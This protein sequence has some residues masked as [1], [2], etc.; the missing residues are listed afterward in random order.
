L[1]EAGLKD[2][3]YNAEAQ[4]I[5]I[6]MKGE[7]KTKDLTFEFKA[8]FPPDY[9]SSAPKVEL[10]SKLEEQETV[11]EGIEKS[12][13]EFFTSWSNFSFLI[14]L[15]NTISRTIFN[16]STLTCILC[17]KIECPVCQQKIAAPEGEESC[18]ARCPHCERDYHDHCWQQTISSFGKCG[19]CL[20]AP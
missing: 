17:H 18:H 15:F 9:P 19:F 11:K 5:L 8:S 2:V 10:L 7:M 6:K 12:I 16:V 4:E 14:D 13:K 3:I 1:L 20:R